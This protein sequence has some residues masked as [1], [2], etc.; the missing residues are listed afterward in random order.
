MPEN[1]PISRKPKWPT[2]KEMLES[3]KGIITLKKEL[4]KKRN[5]L[6]GQSRSLKKQARTQAAPEW[7][8][9]VYNL[10]SQPDYSFWKVLRTLRK[11]KIL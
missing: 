6:R 7:A 4:T 11:H 2:R 3:K 5:Q 9:Q 8:E 10:Y 1:R